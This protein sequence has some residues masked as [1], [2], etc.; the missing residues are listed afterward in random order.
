M[1]MTQQT[2]SMSIPY[3]LESPQWFH[4]LQSKTSDFA[5]LPYKKIERIPY[6]DWLQ[7]QDQFVNPQ[8]LDDPLTYSLPAGVTQTESAKIVHAGLT[9]IYQATNYDLLSQ[10]L[11]VMDLFEAM[12]EHPDLVSKVMGQIVEPNSHQ[13]AARN[14]TQLNGGVF[15]YVPQGMR[16]KDPIEVTWILDNR[17][18]CDFHKK[19]VV[20]ADKQSEF[21]IVESSESR[22]DTQ[23]SVTAC[24]EIQA[25]EQSQIHYVIFDQM[26]VANPAYICRHAE[27]QNGASIH[28]SVMAMNDSHTAE[29]MHTYLLGSDAQSRCSTITIGDGQQKQGINARIT[30]IG[31][32]SIGHIAQRGVVL[33]QATVSFNGIGHILKNAKFADSQQESRILML[34]QGSRGDANPI[35]LIDEFEVQAGHAASIG[36]VDEEQLYYLM[37]RGLDRQAAERLV[38]RGFLGDVLKDLTDPKLREKMSQALDYKLRHF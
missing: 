5:K 27:V 3:W 19:L 4:D 10:G 32:G 34:S 1:T 29:D 12:V 8:L 37:S 9:T 7:Y 16:L 28:W 13:L 26:S 17:Y 11:I 6:P 36:R 15:I 31:H 21:T 33:D 25:C 2:Q 14:M 24:H 23:N 18:E 20:L 38:T 22:G 35:L 30:N